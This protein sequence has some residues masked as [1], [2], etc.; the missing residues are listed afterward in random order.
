MLRLFQASVIHTYAKSASF[1]RVHWN[2]PLVKQYPFT[3]AS[4]VSL[5]YSSI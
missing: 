5:R 1:Y 2:T 4:G 3:T